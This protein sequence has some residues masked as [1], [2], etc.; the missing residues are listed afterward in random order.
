MKM[1]KYLIKVTSNVYY[2]RVVVAENED[3]AINAFIITLDDNDKT[4]EENFDVFSIENL[5]LSKE[6]DYDSY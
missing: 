4:H 2:E 3:K 6:T 5:G 1:N